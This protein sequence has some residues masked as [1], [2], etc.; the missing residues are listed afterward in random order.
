MKYIAATED[1]PARAPMFSLQD[2]IEVC[3][4]TKLAVDSVCRCGP[5]VDYISMQ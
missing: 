3:V 2:F 1:T 4:D 5:T